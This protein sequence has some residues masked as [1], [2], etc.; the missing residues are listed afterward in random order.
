MALSPTPPTHQEV[1][2]QEAERP[3]FGSLLARFD[4]ISLAEM[5]NVA[6]LNRTDTKYVMSVGQLY[7]WGQGGCC[8]TR[9]ML[10]ARWR[11]SF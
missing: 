6:L 3:D 8:W 9:G 4:P 1:R 5:A 2:R 7:C 10:S 11:R